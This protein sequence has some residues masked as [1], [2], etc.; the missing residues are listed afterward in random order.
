MERTYLV[1]VEDTMF[2]NM[3]VKAD[4]MGQAERKAK[5][6]CGLMKSY[7]PGF[8]KAKVLKEIDEVYFKG[9]L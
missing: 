3:I 5:E 7:G 8:V 1:Q 9:G 6:G 2:K 4:D